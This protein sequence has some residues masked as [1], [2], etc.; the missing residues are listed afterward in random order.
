MSYINISIHT[1]P[2]SAIRELIKSQ[3]F[4]NQLNQIMPSINQTSKTLSFAFIHRKK[5][6]KQETK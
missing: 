3:V 5:K 2:T 1:T 4:L 6:I